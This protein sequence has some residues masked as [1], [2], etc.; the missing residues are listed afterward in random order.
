[1]M[2]PVKSFV[3][4]LS[5]GFFSGKAGEGFH[6]SQDD[7]VTLCLHRARIVLASAHLVSLLAPGTMLG[8]FVWFLIRDARID[9]RK[10]P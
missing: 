10:I 9:R 7:P 2:N 8:A 1:M 6:V 5:P 3:P 4:C